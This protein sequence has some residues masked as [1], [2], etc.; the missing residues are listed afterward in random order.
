[1]TDDPRLGAYDALV[2][3]TA[4]SMRPP[5]SAGAVRVEGCKPPSAAN[6]LR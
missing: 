1:M 2:V 4:L 3:P 6:S 5:C